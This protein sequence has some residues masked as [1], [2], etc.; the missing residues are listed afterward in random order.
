MTKPGLQT[1]DM[2]DVFTLFDA[3]PLPKIDFKTALFTLKEAIKEFNFRSEADR[4]RMLAFII[5]PAM[6]TAG[7]LGKTYPMAYFEGEE[8]GTGKYNL[9]RL[10]IMIYLAISAENGTKSDG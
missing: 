8:H 5:G 2:G 3:D 10:I 1:T 4:S 6:K 7:F 9:M